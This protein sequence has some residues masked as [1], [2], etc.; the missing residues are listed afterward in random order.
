[1]KTIGIEGLLRWAY[2]EE[3]Q[4]GEVNA[5]PCPAEPKPAWQVYD[6]WQKLG[7]SVQDG[8]VRNVYGVP[9]SNSDRE[10]HPD[11]VAVFQAVTTLEG[12]LFLAPDGWSP[13]LWLEAHGAQGC[14]AVRRALDGL[15]TD[16]RVNERSSRVVRRMRRPVLSLV[17]RHAICGGAPCWEGE[18]PVAKPLTYDNG[19]PR[20]FLTEC[21]TEQGAFGPVVTSVE[22]DGYDRRCGRPYRGAYQKMRLVPDPVSLITE[23]AEYELWHAALRHLC[24]VLRPRL[25][26]HALEAF[27]RPARPWDD[28]SRGAGMALILSCSPAQKKDADA[29]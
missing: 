8:D 1:M 24:V 28:D 19:K 15:V 18:A 9:P 17:L 22:V 23:R 21:V 14:E 7:T 20:W 29:A 11:A 26:A 27:D 3:L 16:V 13:G 10:P 4:H 6:N 25:E 12:A 2:L 5:R